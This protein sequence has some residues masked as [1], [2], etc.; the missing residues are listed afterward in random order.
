MVVVVVVV[1]QEKEQRALCVA[2]GDDCRYFLIPGMKRKTTKLPIDCKNGK[3]GGEG[4]RHSGG[5]SRPAPAP[6]PLLLL[7]LLLPAP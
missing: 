4:Q 2:F 3:S 6:P 1:V 7:L 5:V